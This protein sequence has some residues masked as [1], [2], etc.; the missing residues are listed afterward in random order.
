MAPP[1]FGMIEWC[2]TALPHYSDITGTAYCLLAIFSHLFKYL[3]L[4]N[5][6]LVTSLGTFFRLLIFSL[7][8]I[9][10]YTGIHGSW[11]FALV[12]GTSLP[13]WMTS[14]YAGLLACIFIRC[15]LLAFSRVLMCFPL[16]LMNCAF[17]FISFSHFYSPVCWSVCLSV[18]SVP[19]LLAWSLTL[20]GTHVG[21]K[22]PLNYQLFAHLIA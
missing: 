20:L 4:H 7:T 19:C 13:A 2:S 10:V 17:N 5:S 14:R 21:F 15:Y 18:Y 9:H 8:P 1:I 22:C 16:C 12:Y 3:S 11:I 6:V